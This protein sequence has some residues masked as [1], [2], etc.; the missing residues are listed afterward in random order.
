MLHNIGDYY[1]LY[2][3]I[4]AQFKILGME[5]LDQYELYRMQKEVRENKEIWQIRK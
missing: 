1:Q 2:E 3:P 4:P 5:D